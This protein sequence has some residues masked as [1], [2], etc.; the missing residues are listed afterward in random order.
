VVAKLSGLA[1]ATGFLLVLL[2][3]PARS[4]ATDLTTP[5]IISGAVAGAV[6]V[7]T[8]TAIMLAEDE[9]PDFFAVS[10]RGMNHDRTPARIRF[11]L[12]CGSLGDQPP[13]LCW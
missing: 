3:L 13:L 7:I 8:L 12:A 4:E 9:E 10:V 5:L 2:L 11:G 1:A 6:A